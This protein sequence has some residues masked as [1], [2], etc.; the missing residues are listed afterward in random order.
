MLRVFTLAQIASIAMGIA[1]AS[2]QTA[3]SHAPEIAPATE[4]PRN[5]AT[6]QAAARR[7]ERDAVCPIGRTLVRR[8][9]DVPPAA[10]DVERDPERLTLWREMWERRAST[11]HRLI[12]EVA[13]CG[14]RAV[15]SC[16][17]VAAYSD[18]P[19]YTGRG[20][21]KI[22]VGAVCLTENGYVSGSTSGSYE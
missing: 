17:E 3:T 1:T 18:D 21:K 2:C 10:P 19:R 9:I 15:Y 13:G 7:F 16:W 12:I 4:D 11:D 6:Q 20:P 22:V 8:I 5:D 14:A